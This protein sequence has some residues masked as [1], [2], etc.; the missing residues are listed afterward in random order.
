MYVWVSCSQRL[1]WE[2]GLP[3]N[4]GYAGKNLEGLGFQLFYCRNQNK[5]LGFG[6]T[7]GNK[8]QP[9][10]EKHQIMLRFKLHHLMQPEFNLSSSVQQRFVL[11]FAEK[12]I[13]L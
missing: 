12:S 7:F 13:V 3:F 10:T 4:L 11:G 2:S 5:L 6:K 1:S 8:F 9:I